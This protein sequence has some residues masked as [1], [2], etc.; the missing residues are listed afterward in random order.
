MT[1]QLL[2]ALEA[3]CAKVAVEL[4]VVFEDVLRDCVNAGSAQATDIASYLVEA[5]RVKEAQI[6]DDASR[7]HDRL[8]EMLIQQCLMLEHDSARL[9]CDWRMH[10]CEVLRPPNASLRVALRTATPDVP[11]LTPGY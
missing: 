8:A 9:T 6:A 4:G 1:L 3:D 10:G 7:M 11:H 2:R 5:Q